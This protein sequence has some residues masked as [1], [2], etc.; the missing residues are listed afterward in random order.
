MIRSE[1]MSLVL[2][3]AERAASSIGYDRNTLK[4]IFQYKLSPDEKSKL[5]TVIVIEVDTVSNK[6]V[7]FELPRLVV[8]TRFLTYVESLLSAREFINKLIKLGYTQKQ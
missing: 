6:Y 8:T 4:A 1:K 3:E 7:I 5:E 2:A